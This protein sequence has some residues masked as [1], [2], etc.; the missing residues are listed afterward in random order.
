MVIDT[1]EVIV[2][3]IG[4]FWVMHDSACGG[5]IPTRVLGENS[6]RVVFRTIVKNVSVLCCCVVLCPASSQLR[7]YKLFGPMLFP[8][9]Y[10]VQMIC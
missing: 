4:C 1:L 8:E 7:S 6:M 2:P 5:L 9:S 10:L 3:F